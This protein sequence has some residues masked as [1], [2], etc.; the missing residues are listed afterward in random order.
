MP[1]PEPA[2]AAA[3]FTQDAAAHSTTAQT[4]LIA[5]PGTGKSNTIVNRLCWL[6]DQV[7]AARIFVVS[8]TRA[9]ANDLKERII[10]ACEECGHATDVTHIQVSTLHSLALRTLRAG[11]LLTRF[12]TPYPLVLDEWE[13]GNV[14][15]VEFGVSS[16][17][18]RR[19][20]NHRACRRHWHHKRRLPRRADRS[21]RR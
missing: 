21:G 1:I 19:R 7:Q 20:G 4:R 14:F 9:S 6:L 15:D 17:G 18:R 13:L 12:P 3:Q 16:R 5:G 8:F 2:K 10:T 11:G